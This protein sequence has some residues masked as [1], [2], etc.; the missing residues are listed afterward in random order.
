MVA[1]LAEKLATSSF[2]LDAQA[3]SNALYGKEHALCALLMSM[4]LSAPDQYWATVAAWSID[5][6]KDFKE[7]SLRG[8]SVRINYSSRKPSQ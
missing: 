4:A 3:I 5:K 2:S 6:V 7:N 1:A 8:E